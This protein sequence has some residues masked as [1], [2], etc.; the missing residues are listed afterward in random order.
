[1]K[2][3]LQYAVT[4]GTPELAPWL[5]QLN[6]HFHGVSSWEKTTTFVTCGGVD[7]V[8]KVLD[9]TLEKGKK[10]NYFFH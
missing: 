10:T 6:E 7:A 2:T 5:R 3:V 1:M 4:S 8:S 9:M